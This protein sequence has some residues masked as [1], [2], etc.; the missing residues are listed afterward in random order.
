MVTVTPDAGAQPYLNGF[1]QACEKHKI[2]DLWNVQECFRWTMQKVEENYGI[3][4]RTTAD[5]AWGF[6]SSEQKCWLRTD[7]LFLT[8]VSKDE[9]K[10]LDE[11]VAALS[12]WNLTL[13]R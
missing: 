9:D 12:S 8:V 10:I 2:E 3:K 11:L 4:K 6:G 5:P 13:N 7:R 1:I